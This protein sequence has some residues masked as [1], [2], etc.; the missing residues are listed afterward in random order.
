MLRISFIA[1]A[2]LALLMLSGGAALADPEWCDSGSPPPNDFRL[3]PTGQASVGSSTGWLASVSG[4]VLDLAAGV[5]TLSGG[6]ASGM[7]ES[8]TNARPYDALPYT[9][10]RAP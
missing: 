1:C 2:T 6:V 9:G 3:R 5:N 10:N 4:G 7:S 8:L